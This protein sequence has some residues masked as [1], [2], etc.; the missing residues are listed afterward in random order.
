MTQPASTSSPTQKTMVL[1]E[2][3][4][5]QSAIFPDENTTTCPRCN[6]TF[7]AECWTENLGCASY[8]CE[9]VNALKPRE[10]EQSVPTDLPQPIPQAGNNRLPVGPILLGLVLVVADDIA[11]LLDPDLFD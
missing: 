6:L 5:C 7:H 11:T 8:G 2:C 4:I 3:G 10:P 1:R 9:Q